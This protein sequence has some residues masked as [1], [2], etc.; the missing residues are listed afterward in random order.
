MPIAALQFVVL[1]AVCSISFF[2]V[3][4][5]LRP[6]VLTVGGITFYLLYA[7]G[8]LWLVG[9]AVVMTYLL[10]E[11]R[12]YW[13]AVVVLALLLAVFKL[14]GGSVMGASLLGPRGFG[15]A[16]VP[17]G[18]SFL[19]F[20]LIHY[21]VDRGRGRIPARSFIGLAAFAFFFPCRV[22]GPIK[23]YPDFSEEVASA[24]LLP[25]NVSRGCIR[26]AAG[27]IKKIALA[28]PLGSVAAGLAEATTALDAWTSALSYSFQLY[29]DFSAYS[30]IAVG[31]SLL[32]GIRVPE[33]FNWP[34]LSE[35]IQE[36]WRRWHMSLSSWAQDYVF[37]NVGRALFKTR[38][39]ARPGA[40]ATISYVMAFLTIGAWH[41]LTPNFLAWGAYHGTLM[42]TFHFYKGLVPVSVATSALYRS[43]VGRWSA[44]GVT[45][46][47]VTIGWVFFR[48]D[49]SEAVRTLRLMLMGHRQG[50]V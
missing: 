22:A 28:D 40:I 9:S 37:A 30:D 31:I 33:N 44:I 36:F 42:V 49:P 24:H 41:G 47:L 50:T 46:F 8:A 19:A 27:L 6:H 32:M 34:Y 35:N 17:L 11:R 5:T 2:L 15:D 43:S 38:L 4:R 1:V 39:R 21:A 10:S 7:A 25:E 45:F 20:E 29:L 16:A 12:T 18:F 13:L 3:P 14:P 23:R 48:L 26:I